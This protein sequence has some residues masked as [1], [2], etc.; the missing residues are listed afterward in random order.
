MPYFIETFQ[1]QEIWF[2]PLQGQFCVGSQFDQVLS[3]YT[4]SHVKQMIKVC[5][6]MA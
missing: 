6:A 3:G 5:S 1:G 4:V 2:H